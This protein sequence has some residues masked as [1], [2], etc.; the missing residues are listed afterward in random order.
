MDHASTPCLP[1]GPSLNPWLD[2]Y[3]G[4]NLCRECFDRSVA[5]IP[6][7][8]SRERADAWAVAAR[9]YM[10][11][12]H[13]ADAVR[14][15]ERAEKSGGEEVEALAIFLAPDGLGLAL[16]RA[17]SASRPAVRADRWCDL[18]ALRVLQQGG[19]GAGGAIAEALAACPDHLEAQHWLRF[20]ALP[21][22]QREADR[23]HGRPSRRGRGLAARDAAALIPHRGNG[24]IG[25]R[26]LLTR[27]ALPPQRRSAPAG[28]GLATLDDAGVVSLY[29]GSELDYHHLPANSSLVRAEIAL[30]ILS[31]HVDEGRHAAPLA[32]AAWNTALASG[33][34]LR[35]QDLAEQLCALATRAPDLLDAGAACADWLAAASP[36]PALFLA[37]GAWIAAARGS[38]DAKLRAETVLA[39]GDANE[40]VW[41]LA[42]GALYRL[43]AVREGETHLAAARLDPR[44]RAIAASMH[45]AG[46]RPDHPFVHCSPRLRS[47]GLVGDTLY[48]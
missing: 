11:L 39:R 24:W 4:A 3:V 41:R 16:R 29:L 48:S 13:P 7:L 18:A 32:R 42:V 15:W 20:L 22:A 47:R 5:C 27:H 36:A 8:P 40:L 44:M 17:Q 21:D 30:T 37:Y 25:E 10:L 45:G 31:D 26:R 19:F 12:G 33:D 1:L 34:R 38:P 35:V 6:T 28:S 43:G 2:L 23:L 14:A 46:A 9:A